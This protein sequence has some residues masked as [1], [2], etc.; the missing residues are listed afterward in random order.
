MDEDL[1][2]LF[3][4]GVS[5][6]FNSVDRLGWGHGGLVDESAVEPHLDEIGLRAEAWSSW[7][8]QVQI[9]SKCS[10]VYEEF[11][12][13]GSKLLVEIPDKSLDDSSCKIESIID[14]R[15]KS[16][17]KLVDGNLPGELLDLELNGTEMELWASN[18]LPMNSILSGSLWGSNLSF[19]RDVNNVKS[20]ECALLS[21][22]ASNIS[23][24]GSINI[25]AREGE[26]K[27]V[28][29]SIFPEEAVLKA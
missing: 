7:G 13:S 20:L 22:E 5:H 26:D 16:W 23:L 29:N 18:N 11:W 8:G 6:W 3:V 1:V 15:D 10:D 27:S 21:W 25:K 19:N 2:E 4:F 14:S 28:I 17:Q 24:K 12:V 9:S